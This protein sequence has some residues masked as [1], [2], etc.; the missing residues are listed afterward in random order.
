MKFR[1]RNRVEKSTRARL[2]STRDFHGSG[3]SWRAGDAAF[4]PPAAGGWRFPILR[5]GS[6]YPCPRPRTNLNPDTSE[7]NAPLRQ[8]SY[9]FAA[10]GRPVVPVLV[11][12]APTSHGVDRQR[13]GSF[14]P[15]YPPPRPARPVCSTIPPALSVVVDV[16]R[17]RPKSREFSTRLFLQ[18]PAPT[19]YGLHSSW[20]SAHRRARCVTCVPLCVRASGRACKRSACVA[21][22]R[23]ARAIPTSIWSVC[24]SVFIS[25][26]S[27]RLSAS[28]ILSL[29]PSRFLRQ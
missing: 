1:Y 6:L 9:V 20:H 26:P 24:L 19:T 15:V 22:R 14:A 17:W 12:R 8:R 4:C 23:P 25:V 18:V 10:A 27:I 2:V 5:F 13:E 7:R 21:N 28:G 11:A 3:G 16:R 29:F